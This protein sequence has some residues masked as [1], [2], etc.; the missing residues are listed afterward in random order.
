MQ[1][2]SPALLISI[3]QNRIVFLLKSYGRLLHMSRKHDD[4]IRQLKQPLRERLLNLTVISARQVIAPIGA[5]KQRVS[6]EENPFL[7][8]IIAA[9]T[10]CMPGRSGLIRSPLLKRRASPFSIG[11]RSVSASCSS[12]QIGI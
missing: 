12:A 1:T 7:R 2:A 11:S 8:N 9:G 5:L 4:I 6:G 10:R 3:V